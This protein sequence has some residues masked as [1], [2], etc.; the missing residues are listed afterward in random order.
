ML[1]CPSKTLKP[2]DIQ[3]T[4]MKDKEK[5]GTV[6]FENQETSF[7][8]ATSTIIKILQI[9]LCFARLT[10]LEKLSL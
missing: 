1:F 7:F 9:K 2:E 8:G 6:T 10:G 3:F 5:W 4:K